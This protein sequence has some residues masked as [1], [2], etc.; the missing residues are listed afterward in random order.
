[1]EYFIINIIHTHVCDYNVL[2]IKSKLY[3]I[4]AFLKKKIQNHLYK[5]IQVGN[6]LLDFGRLHRTMPNC[7]HIMHCAIVY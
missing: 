4:G 3:I 6:S 7:F 1:M 2:Q 5:N